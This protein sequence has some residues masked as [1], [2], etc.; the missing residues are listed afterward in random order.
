[1]KTKQILKI[2]AA[3]AGVLCALAFFSNGHARGGGSG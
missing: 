2:S 1:M 3:P